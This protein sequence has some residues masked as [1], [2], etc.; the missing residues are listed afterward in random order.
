MYK[1]DQ[2]IFSHMRII[3]FLDN[4]F[5]KPKKTLELHHPMSHQVSVNLVII[6][7]F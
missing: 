5:N 2:K 7:I 3:C 1:Y 6:L 4:G